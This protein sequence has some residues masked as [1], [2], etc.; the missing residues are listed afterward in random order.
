[1][2]YNFYRRFCGPRPWSAEGT[3]PEVWW[4]SSRSRGVETSSERDWEKRPAHDG[5]GGTALH[6]LVRLL[7]S[8]LFS[9]KHRRLR[10][11][12]RVFLRFIDEIFLRQML[13]GVFVAVENPRT[14]AIWKE[15]FLRKWADVQLGQFVDL[16]MC[17][18][19]LKSSD[20]SNFFGR[21]CGFWSHTRRL[22][23]CLLHFVLG[24]TTTSRSKGRRRPTLLH[25]FPILVG[26][27]QRRWKGSW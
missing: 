4:W 26:L 12:E 23:K 27:S 2:K 18:F 9:Q 14:S 13:H 25:T 7:K 8:Q 11:K 6:I 19:G 21:L 5:M 1:M 3:R 22:P 10:A 17:A 24:A 16:E 15:Q 20:G